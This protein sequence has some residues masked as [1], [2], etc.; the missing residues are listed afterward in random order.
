MGGSILWA[1]SLDIHTKGSFFFGSFL[2][3]D[4]ELETDRWTSGW[5]GLGSFGV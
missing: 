1:G 5:I 2:N 3:A 4:P